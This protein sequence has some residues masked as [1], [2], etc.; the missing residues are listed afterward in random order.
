MFVTSFALPL[1]TE[2]VVKESYMVVTGGKNDDDDDDG[3]VHVKS[4][5][6]GMI[7]KYSYCVF[8][9]YE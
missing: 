4:I 9:R 3:D 5:M 7:I 6:L 2:V 1:H 8:L